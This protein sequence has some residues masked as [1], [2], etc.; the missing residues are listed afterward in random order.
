MRDRLSE[1]NAEKIVKALV[2]IRKEKGI[3]QY[4][5]AQDSGLSRSGLNA[6]ERG[7]QSPKIVT[8]LKICRALDVDLWKVI[9]DSK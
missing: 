6:I 2:R 5:L 8:C 7:Q 4:K 3:S 1:K 9:K